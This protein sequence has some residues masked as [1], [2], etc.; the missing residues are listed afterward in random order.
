M[1]GALVMNILP[2]LSTYSS[3]SRTAVVRMFITSE[4]WLGSVIACAVMAS[5]EVT[6]GR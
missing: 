6:R 3:P 5:P 1:T 4:P 2:P